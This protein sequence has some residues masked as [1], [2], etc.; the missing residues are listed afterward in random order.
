MSIK[1]P[2]PRPPWRLVQLMRCVHAACGPDP[3]L[4]AAA[5]TVKAR[6]GRESERERERERERG[7]AG[8]RFGWHGELMEF[9]CR[10]PRINYATCRATCPMQVRS[11]EADP[12]VRSQSLVGIEYAGSAALRSHTRVY[13]QEEDAGRKPK[14]L[15][16]NPCS[17]AT[18]NTDAR[19]PSATH[20]RAQTRLRPPEAKD[21][22]SGA[23]KNARPLVTLRFR[24]ASNASGAV[25]R[26]HGEEKPLAFCQSTKFLLS[27]RG[28]G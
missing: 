25:A 28:G 8:G 10:Q 22:L 19:G 9:V 14:G 11:H 13:V 17:H 12:A 26:A 1:V 6:P 27:S 7:R 21:I 16:A 5:A 2:P 3:I 23:E 15:R 18:Q 20:G 4:A 24:D